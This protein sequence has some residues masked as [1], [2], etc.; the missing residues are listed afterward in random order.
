ML[1]EAQKKELKLSASFRAQQP[2]K[3]VCPT[4]HGGHKGETSFSVWTG[5]VGISYKC[6]RLTCGESGLIPWVSGAS[7]EYIPPKKKKVFG[8]ETE[9]LTFEHAS[10]FHAKYELSAEELSANGVV[11]CPSR[12]SFIF[13]VFNYSGWEIGKM[14]RWYSWWRGP[15]YGLGRKALYYTESEAPRIYFPKSGWDT[16]AGTTR[17]AVQAV[18]PLYIVED[19]LSAIK[20]S[21]LGTT[22]ALLGTHLSHEVFEELLR[23]PCSKFVFILDP[24]A[25]GKAIEYQEKFGLLKPIEVRYL[26]DDPKDTP[27]EELRR[28]LL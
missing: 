20:M 28:C 26:E 19:C 27:M 23:V 5:E 8:H 15:P 21:R 1:S 11:Y 17:Q 4:C 14:E 25:F 7:G 18:T 2:R 16:V 10:F 9:A 6:W 24:D 3:T 22:C 13:P 12:G